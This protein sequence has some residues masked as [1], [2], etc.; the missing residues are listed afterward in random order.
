M[1]NLNLSADQV[2]TTTRAVRKR[3]DFDKPVAMSTLEE[4]LQIAVQAPSGS[5]SQGWHFVL[6][7]DQD[8]KNEIAKWYQKSF[9]EYEAGPAQPTKLHLDDPSMEQVQQRV[10][11]SAQYLAENMARVPAMLIPCA[12]GRLD[13][14]GLPLPHAAGAFGSIIPA[15]WSFMLA[16]R[17]RGIGTC[18]TTLHLNYEK[19]IAELLNIPADFTQVALIPIA[20][21]LGTDFKI[22][23]RKPLDGILHTNQW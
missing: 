23:P 17:A 13:A 9:A 18:W 15:V 2:L 22:A 8:K 10:L 3:M 14:P 1:S 16:A 21:T 12:T 4:C 5:N 6:V 20:Y 11:G 19:E 7:T